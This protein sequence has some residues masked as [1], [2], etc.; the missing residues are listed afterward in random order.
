MRQSLGQDGGMPKKIPS[1]ERDR[2]R[3]LLLTEVDRLMTTEYP[4]YTECEEATAHVMRL[5]AQARR[6]GLL[7][8]AKSARLLRDVKIDIGV[9]KFYQSSTVSSHT[10]D[11]LA[12]L[13]AERPG[14]TLVRMFEVGLTAIAAA[15]SGDS[16]ALSFTL[17][18]KPE[19]RIELVG[20]DTALS[21][22]LTLPANPRGRRK[23]R[24]PQATAKKRP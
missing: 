1:T 18:Q 13:M 22:R 23:S 12:A 20:N 2:A 21:R 4:N 3:K 9:G 16:T 19:P 14:W 7:E 6:D 10:Y 24:A 15:E 8:G 11:R 5:L 17:Q